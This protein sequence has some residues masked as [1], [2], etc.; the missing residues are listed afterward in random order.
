MMIARICPNFAQ[1]YPERAKKEQKEQV[2]KSEG[3]KLIVSAAAF[4]KVE[5]K[6]KKEM[7][8]KLPVQL[9]QSVKRQKMEQEQQQQSTNEFIDDNDAMW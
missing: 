4:Q 3:G 8:V 5:E 6:R 7:R 2:V 1:N 9:L